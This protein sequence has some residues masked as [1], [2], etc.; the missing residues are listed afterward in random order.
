VV[1]D[2]IEVKIRGVDSQLHKRFVRYAK[3]KFK[4]TGDMYNQAIDEFLLNHEKGENPA[5]N[6]SI[7]K[8]VFSI[9]FNQENIGGKVRFIL[10]WLIQNHIGK[11]SDDVDKIL[12]NTWKYVIGEEKYYM[13]YQ[14]FLENNKKMGKENP[15][16]ETR[17]YMQ[18]VYIV[19]PD[20]NFDEEFDR[21]FTSN[22]DCV[23]WVRTRESLGRSVTDL[24]VGK[25]EDFSLTAI[26]EVIKQYE[27]NIENGRDYYGVMKTVLEKLENRKQFLEGLVY[28]VANELFGP[29]YNDNKTQKTLMKE[30]KTRSA[31]YNS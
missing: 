28:K 3:K 11:S 24:I 19:L 27:S 18:K 2:K 12:N 20:E 1:Q 7:E 14:E 30:I 6:N 8:R 29:L 13:E 23:V 9:L 4:N 10:D 17:K 21:R 15:E 16:E 22:P 5:T 31:Q 26:I 25:V